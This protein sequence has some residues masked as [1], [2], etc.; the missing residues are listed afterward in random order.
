MGFL[1]RADE[2]LPLDEPMRAAS[3]Y[4]ALSSEQVR[5]AFQRWIRPDALVKVIEGP[6]P[7]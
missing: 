4:L 2:G 5:E 6:S 7:K 1:G 3:R